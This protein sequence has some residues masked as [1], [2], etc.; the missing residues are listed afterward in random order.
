MKKLFLCS[1]CH[2]GVLGGALYLDVQAVTYRTQ[3]LTVDQKYRELVLP[4]QEIESLT[5]KTVLAVF[6]M[7]SGEEYRLLIFNK[8]RFEK[9]YRAYG[10]N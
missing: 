4:L 1:L 5:W 10:G 8:P 7:K 2:N 3:K 9:W 6:R